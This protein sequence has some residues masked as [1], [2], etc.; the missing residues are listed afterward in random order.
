MVVAEAMSSG[1]VLI[2]T[3][4][5]GAYEVVVH[6]VDGLLVKPGDSKEL[7]EKLMWCIQNE[8]KMEKI[9]KKGIKNARLRFS[10]ERGA[11]TLDENFKALQE[12]KI[13][14]EVFK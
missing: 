12:K 14:L 4:V 3:G 5:G 8:L 9:S 13:R 10:Q 2:T 11:K 7:Y 1:V 6:E